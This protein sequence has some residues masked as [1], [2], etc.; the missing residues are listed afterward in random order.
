[1][2]VPTMSRTRTLKG[3][4]FQNEVLGQI[5]PFGRLLFAGLWTIADRDGR[6]EDRPARIVAELFPYDRDL[7][8]VD[9]DHLLMLLDVGG[10]IVRYQVDGCAYIEI[11]KW[12][13]HQHPHPREVASTIPAYNN[14]GNCKRKQH[15]GDAKAVSGNGLDHAQGHAK[16]YVEPGGCSGSTGST[17]STD[18]PSGMPGFSIHQTL[19]LEPSLE[20][21]TEKPARGE[22]LAEGWR[23]PLQWGQWAMHECG[24]THEQVTDQASRFADHWHAAAGRNAAKLDWQ[25]TWRNWCRRARDEGAYRGPPRRAAS[26]HETR[27]RTAEGFGVA[28]RER[29]VIDLPPEDCHAIPKHH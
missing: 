9:V 20:P 26:L 16:V 12:T 25:A 11:V 19:S 27:R 6:L 14:G 23:L 5:P 13:D 15:L 21:R 3:K 22:R 4:F 7:C 17:G 2:M 24:M 29:D 1:M 10:L 8:A 28:P 18:N